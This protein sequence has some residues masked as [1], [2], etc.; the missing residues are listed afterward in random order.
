M[1]KNIEAFLLFKV[2]KY[3]KIFSFEDC[4]LFKNKINHTKIYLS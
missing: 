1:Y 4:N 3:H 2:Q